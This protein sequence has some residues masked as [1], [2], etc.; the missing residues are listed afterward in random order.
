MN[1]SSLFP[2]GFLLYAHK[3]QLLLL[4]VLQ[5]LANLRLLRFDNQQNTSYQKRWVT[6]TA[7][8]WRVHAFFVNFEFQTKGSRRSLY[9]LIIQVAFNIH[10]WVLRGYLNMASNLISFFSFQFHNLLSCFLWTPSI[11][12]ETSKIVQLQGSPVGLA[13]PQGPME[14][15]MARTNFLE[16]QAASSSFPTAPGAR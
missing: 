15:R 9:K 12:Q 1:H 10:C 5:Y 11:E 8:R 14:R 13:L 3:L 4:N 7:R 2:E 16:I 6:S